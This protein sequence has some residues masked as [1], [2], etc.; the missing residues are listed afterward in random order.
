MSINFQKSPRL[1]L[2]GPSIFGNLTGIGIAFNTLISGLKEFGLPHE[3]VYLNPEGRVAV[4]GSFDFHRLL[5]SLKV[6]FNV[7]SRLFNSHTIYMTISSSLL[8]FIRDA[9]IIWPAY[10]FR[11]RIVLHLNGGGYRYFYQEQF[12]L[13]Q[14][15]IRSTLVRV[16]ALIVLGELLRDQFYFLPDADHKI[17]IVPNGLPDDLTPEKGLRKRIIPSEPIRLL[18]LSNMI[19]SKGYED[20]LKACQ[21]LHDEFQIPIQCDFCGSFLATNTSHEFRSCSPEAAREKFC[22]AIEDLELSEIVHYWGA[23][24]GVRKQKLLT[25]AHLLVLP[26]YYPWEGQPVSIIEALAFSTPVI[27]TR[28][29]GIPEEVLDGYN[30][31]L[32]DPKAPNQIAQAVKQLWENPDIYQGMSIKAQTHYQQHFTREKYLERLITVLIR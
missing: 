8:G 30:G 5:V 7:W 2:I 31:I 29:H 25:A 21:L 19:A 11:K 20:V 1:L 9:M 28:H 23:V 3:I 6:L 18:Y 10:L 27:S 15:C 24:Y 14:W 22:K 13:I 26:T 32:V 4:A 16:D 12:P 17:H